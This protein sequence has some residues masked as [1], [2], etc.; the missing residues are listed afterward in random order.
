MRIARPKAPAA[1]V[2]LISF[3][4][5]DLGAAEAQ[6]LPTLQSLPQEVKAAIQESVKECGTEKAA[7]KWGFVVAQDVNGDGVRRLH[8]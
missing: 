5:A 8:P 7:L 4:V 6:S 2:A 3:I 1:I